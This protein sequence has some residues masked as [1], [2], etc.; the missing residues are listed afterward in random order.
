[1]ATTSA[2]TTQRSWTWGDRVPFGLLIVG[3]TLG[4][5]G[6]GPET[7]EPSSDVIL[8]V[9]LAIYLLPPV[10]ALVASFRWPLLAARLGLVAGVLIVGL[11]LLDM[12]GV[13]IGP[14]P[15]GMMFVDALVIV[16]AV[17]LLWRS[18]LVAR[19]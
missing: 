2:A 4:T 3:F 16:A 17:G 14:P 19:A 7:R 10:A 9:L 11:V 18:W 1:M 12:A 8:A 15:T 5:P 6:L 13:L